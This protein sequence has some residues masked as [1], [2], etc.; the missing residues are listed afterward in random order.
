MMKKVLS[1]VQM[2]SR[3]GCDVRGNSPIY[4]FFTTTQPVLT[5]WP[6]TAPGRSG[7]VS[8]YDLHGAE[9]GVEAAADAD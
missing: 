5:S 3:S 8:G 6:P 7:L 1:W 9:N 2:L 4:R